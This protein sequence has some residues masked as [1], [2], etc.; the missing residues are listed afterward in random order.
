MTHIRL[1]HYGRV[2]GDI[3]GGVLKLGV[4]DPDTI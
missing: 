2:F 4:K 1:I 3:L